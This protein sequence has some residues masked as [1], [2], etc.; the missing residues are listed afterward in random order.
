MA[1]RW[2]SLPASFTD[3]ELQKAVI[4]EFCVYGEVHARI[5]RE[6]KD[7]TTLPCAY[8]QFTVR[9]LMPTSSHTLR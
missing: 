1:D 4:E 8:L 6:K 2:N 9:L 5:F 7:K 3:P